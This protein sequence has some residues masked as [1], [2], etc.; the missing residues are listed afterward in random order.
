[1][2][3]RIIDCPAVGNEDDAVRI[4]LEQ[5]A[6][7]EVTS[8]GFNTES[9]DSPVT[10]NFR[11][12]L[13]WYFSE[14]PQKPSDNGDDSGVVSKLIKCGQSI[15]EELLGEDHE[16]IKLTEDIEQ[17]GYHTLQVRIESSR[18]AFFTELWE[19]TILPESKYI[20][21]TVV[22]GYVR[23]FEQTDLAADAFPPLSFDLKV[24]PPSQDKVNQLLQAENITPDNQDT[25]K[26]DEQPLGI[27]T[28][29]SRARANEL[30]FASSNSINVSLQA[31]AAGGAIDYDICQNTDWQ[32]LTDRLA[33]HS[34]PVHIF[35][36]D[37]PVL[38]N[39][40]VASIILDDD[41]VVSIDE[42]AK[43]LVDNNVAALSIDAR[44]YLSDTEHNVVQNPAQGLAM[45]AQAAHQQGLGNVI[46]LGQIT[47]PWTASQCF[48]TI[49]SQIVAGLSLDQAVVE[50]RK[51]LQSNTET[52]LMTTQPIPFH[53]WS[54]LVHYSL[55]SVNF[56]GV[57]SLGEPDAPDDTAQIHEKLFGFRTQMLPPMLSQVSDGQVLQLI[58]PL[59]GQ[60]GAGVAVLGEQGSGKSQLAHVAC[61]YLAQKQ[62][63]D[64]GFYFDFAAN[65]YTPDDMLEM[66]APV[67]GLEVKDTA[68]VVEKLST[69]NC[70]FVLDDMVT[71]SLSDSLKAL[72]Q[73]LSSH[74]HKLIITG[75]VAV[76]SSE[77]DELVT[78][79]IT[80]APLHLV[81]Q[82][83]IA[84]EQL[85]QLGLA[86]PE[87]DQ[88]KDFADLLTTV[89]GH[90]WLTS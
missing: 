50:A 57:P 70:C 56:F 71:V 65:D 59:Q 52:A 5:K 80:L 46:G 4:V 67:I 2:L 27:L 69:L 48:E 11:K 26:Q 16:L 63:L 88:A 73:S 74:G 53:P 18:L 28:L 51:A 24:T 9:Y 87:Q 22:N 3:L 20:L 77:L 30:P 89:G 83:I 60:Q 68:K 79:V 41:S 54:L 36:Y 81:E 8:T 21:S 85:R 75:D 31:M 17:Q 61:V 13:A 55:Q 42:L 7:N 40:D 6:Q 32:Q 35:H 84:A 10:D 44:A 37:G 12:V 62:Q 90:P 15:G 1:M 47:D 45:I 78:S 66:I 19:T 25:D 58:E 64:Y 14:Y 34:Q 23:R 38:L 49:Y 72:L 29:V 43:V 86:K 76:H 33:D 39:N 82:K